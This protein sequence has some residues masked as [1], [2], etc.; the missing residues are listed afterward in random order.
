MILDAVRKPVIAFAG[1]FLVGLAI[2]QVV[3]LSSARKDALVARTETSTLR[4]DVER[5]AREAEAKERTK[6]TARLKFAQ[7]QTHE[8]QTHYEQAKVARAVATVA[9]VSLRERTD[10]VA[11]RCS[12]ERRD[13]APPAGSPPAD[14]PGHLL[15]QLSGRLDEAAEQFADFAERSALAAASCAARYDSLT[16]ATP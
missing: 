5:K 10:A 9:S 1:V 3:A 15:A 7:E 16:P 6:E 2:W 14:P 11:A 8:D 4:A 12:E 13:P